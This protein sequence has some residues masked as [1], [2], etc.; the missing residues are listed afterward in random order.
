MPRF[1]HWSCAE[2]TSC[3]AANARHN[4]KWTN[5]FN[6]IIWIDLCKIFQN[7]PIVVNGAL[8]FKL[9]DVAK[10]MYK[11]GMI[12]TTWKEDGISDGLTAMIDAIDYY[13]GN[14]S[15]DSTR[16]LDIMNDNEHNKIDSIRIYNEVDCKVMWDIV[17]YLR[18]N[19]I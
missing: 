9:K 5:W 1:F 14:K 16:N 12:K 2:I 13:K 15:Y 6:S 17:R 7:E 11:H 10:N 3:M 8:S 18:E 4:S 19:H